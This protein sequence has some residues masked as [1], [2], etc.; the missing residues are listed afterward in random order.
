[1]SYDDR[2]ADEAVPPYLCKDAA[3][4]DDGRIDVELD[5]RLGR[6]LSTL[7]R[8]PPDDG[9]LASQPP[10][11]IR[12]TTPEDFPLRLNIVIHVVGSRGDV[13]PFVALGSELQK[14]G[15][16]VRLATHGM[17]EKFVHDAGLEFYSIRGDP[18]DLMSYMVKN[19]GLIPSMQSLRAGEI[20]RKR[21]MIMEMLGGCW[22]SCTEAD[23]L[24]EQPFVANAIIANPPSFAHI[25][26]AEALGIPVHLVFTMPWTATSSFPH[27]LANI[28]GSRTTDMKVANYLSYILVECMTW[29]GLGDVIN[30]WRKGIGLEPVPNTEGPLL[31]S[32]LSIPF[33]YCWSP[34]LIPKP[35]DWA[36]NIDVSGFFFREL[37]DYTPSD[38]LRA[39]LDAGAPP[40][41]IG[42]G[43]II[44]DDSVAMSSL[45]QEAVSAC[46]LRAIISRGWSGLDGPVRS[47]IFW[48]GDCPHEWLFQH[49]STV[50][51]HGGAGTAA[52]GLRNARPTV[53]VPFFGDQPFWGD[54]VAAAGAGPA[55]IP[56]K[57]LN[58]QML[59]EA[60]R[61]CQK[62]EVKTA[63]ATIAG[64]MKHENGVRNAVMSFLNNL[65]VEDMQCDF[66]HDQPASW[67][68]KVGK[69]VTKISI[70]AA[71]ILVK[72]SGVNPRNLKVYRPHPIVIENRRWDP[73]TGLTSSLVATSVDLAGAVGGIFLKPA[74]EYRRG[75]SRSKRPKS[76]QSDD[77]D[78]ARS[79]SKV[80]KSSGDSISTGEDFPLL[81]Q[82][83]PNLEPRLHQD[84]TQDRSH[85]MAVAG[86]MALASGK[87]L[88]KV[89]PTFY[90]AVLVDW[91]LAMTEGFRG[92]PRL[93][94][95]E[96]KDYGKV[97]D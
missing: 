83:D 38:D 48:L 25:H 57:T 68:L 72:E 19:P 78:H 7:V 34:A 53:I 40:V 59:S 61:F 73:A 69:N 35:V 11:Y 79:Q 8:L 56:H 85:H 37:P 2:E 27:P 30:I 82:S 26:C 50:V 86:S 62:D 13:Q 91:P 41:Y 39:F 60:L 33:T 29:Q 52:C 5:S 17:F 22:N 93:W 89:V 24:T 32:T 84:E 15:H 76:R 16:R 6:T 81:A 58:S 23:P 96:V 18:G 47:D 43:S 80:T 71:E 88:G 74:Q 46:G 66:L 20:S 67:S 21:E 12:Y 54:M 14:Y 42:F 31:A 36:A 28:S 55:P 70:L 9:S 65:P 3:L 51:H 1:M 63:A 97:T 4:K 90:K 45:I 87:S 75:R 95:E 44:L 64:K 77:C 92:M 49:V 94:G 10:R